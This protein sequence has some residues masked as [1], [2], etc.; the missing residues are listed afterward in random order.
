MLANLGSTE[1]IIALFVLTVLFGGKKMN[2]IAKGLGETSKEYKKIKKEYEEVASQ[3]TEK[4]ASEVKSTEAEGE[5]G[6]EKDEVD[7]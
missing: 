7:V 1:I 6:K 3:K 2:E 4:K 5:G